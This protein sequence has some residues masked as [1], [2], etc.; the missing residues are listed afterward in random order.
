MKSSPCLHSGHWAMVVQEKQLF[1]AKGNQRGLS[2]LS[3]GMKGICNRTMGC[4]RIN[5]N[6][7]TDLICF[8]PKSLSNNKLKLNVYICKCGSHSDVYLIPSYPSG[9]GCRR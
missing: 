6:I 4:M 8:C 3:W 7:S 2:W 1:P 9:A 5:S